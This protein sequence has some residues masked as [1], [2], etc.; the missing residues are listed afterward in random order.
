MDGKQ[1]RGGWRGWSRGRSLALR[2]PGRSGR[3]RYSDLSS[4]S[5]YRDPYRNHLHT[6]RGFLWKKDGLA[7]LT[8]QDSPALVRHFAMDGGELSADFFTLFASR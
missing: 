2:G 1:E 5:I 4:L 7:C 8:S 6:R 3:C